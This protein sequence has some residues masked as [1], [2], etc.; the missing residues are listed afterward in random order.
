MKVVKAIV[1]HI[2]N[3]GSNRPKVKSRAA[4]LLQKKLQ[5]DVEAQRTM[6][7]LKDKWGN[8]YDYNPSNSNSL[9]C[10]CHIRGRCWTIS[11]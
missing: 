8:R 6:D 11:K 1:N 7:Y 3:R 4:I 10:S 2:T 5:R 9:W